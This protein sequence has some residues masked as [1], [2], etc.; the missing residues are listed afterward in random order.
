MIKKPQKGLIQNT[1]EQM[2]IKQT[3]KSS[4]KV[5][6]FKE[7]SSEKQHKRGLTERREAYGY[8][9][10]DW[11]HRDIKEDREGRDDSDVAQNNFW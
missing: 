9:N 4:I 5:T 3:G 1:F 11:K 10:R 6:L 7:D 2:G 8:I